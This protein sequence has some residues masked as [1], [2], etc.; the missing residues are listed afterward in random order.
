MAQTVSPDVEG[1]EGPVLPTDDWVENEVLKSA[2]GWVEVSKSCLVR[3]RLISLPNGRV[4]VHVAAF[5][6]S[7]ASLH[8][9]MGFRPLG[10]I[11]PAD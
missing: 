8:P 5:P 3:L 4:S 1:G 9:V 10:P 6:A 11:D 7:A 2:T